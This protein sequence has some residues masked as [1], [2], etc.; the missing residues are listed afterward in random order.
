MKSY[1]TM[2][3][4]IETED[5][6][7]IAFRAEDSSNRTNRIKTYEEIAVVLDADIADSDDSDDKEL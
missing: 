6:H 5:F 7:N 2:I 1:Q 3:E 4:I